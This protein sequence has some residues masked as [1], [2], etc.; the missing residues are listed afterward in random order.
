M[1]HN[2]PRNF[3][4]WWSR[5]TVLHVG[6]HLFY[7]CYLIYLSQARVNNG[8]RTQYKQEISFQQDEFWILATKVELVETPSSIQDMELRVV[9]STPF[10]S[11]NR[12]GN[13]IE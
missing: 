7:L 3:L 8:F 1:D 9:G 4:L 12:V 13:N 6:N 11:L 5:I 2:R 10:Y